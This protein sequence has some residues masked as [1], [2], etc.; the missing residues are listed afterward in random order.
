MTTRDL[1]VAPAAR[2]GNGVVREVE[3]GDRPVVHFL[4]EA[5][6]GTEFLWFHLTASNPAGRMIRFVWENLYYCLGGVNQ[7]HNI[8]PVYR[9]D[10]GPWTRFDVAAL[11]VLEHP[12]RRKLA[13]TTPPADGTVSVA[14]CYPYDSADLA[15]MLKQLPSRPE[16][17]LVALSGRNRLIHRYRFA[18]EIANRPGVYVMARQHAGETPGSWVMDGIFRHLSEAGAG[19]TDW[20]LLPFADI[21]GVAEGLY[22]KDRFP[23][24][25][26]RSWNRLPM[27][28][29]LNGY[30][31]DI[32]EFVA[33]TS[34]HLLVDLHAPGHSEDGFYTYGP[35]KGKPVERAHVSERWGNLVGAAVAK[36]MGGP[37]EKM[38]RIPD[39][40]SRWG[41]DTVTAWVWKNFKMC[42]C[43]TE[44]SYQSYAGKVLTVE[45]YRVIGRAVVAAAADFLAR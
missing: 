5:R 44:T 30:Q 41:D 33:G 36:T 29:E 25:F 2:S 31:H 35:R 11:E 26:N 7:V 24:D 8:R 42:G 21:D 28:P 6:D 10:D 34:R 16:E 23:W 37:C 38:Y 3:A 12:H 13:F 17:T 39:Y 22:G 4:S 27:R 45:D 43:G 14:F 20:W 15:A 1:Q 19:G 40:P 9:L 18:A 32:A